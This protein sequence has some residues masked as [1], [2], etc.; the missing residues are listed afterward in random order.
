MEN[1]VIVV[2]RVDFDAWVVEQQILAEAAGQT[3]EG[4]GQALVVANGC[5]ACHSI[6]GSA[7][8]G[9]TWFGLYGHEVRLS[10][11][12]IVVA[13]EEY[14]AESILQPQ[15]KIV[16][17]FENQQMPAYNFTDEQIAD[18]IAYIKTLR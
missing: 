15:A 9:P 10:D 11:G 4:R 7:R 1:P 5:A 6:D 14:L 17:G 16:A 13:D 3:P 18:I 12:S 2:E 8:V